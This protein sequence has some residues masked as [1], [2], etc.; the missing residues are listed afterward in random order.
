MNPEIFLRY[1]RQGTYSPAVQLLA[2]FEGLCC[3]QLVTSLPVAV[4]HVGQMTQGIPADLR[5][6]EGP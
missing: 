6:P 5:F 3:I 1:E 2:Y 4:M